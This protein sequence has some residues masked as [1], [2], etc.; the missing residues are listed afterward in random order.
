MYGDDQEYLTSTSAD[1]I[2]IEGAKNMYVGDIVELSETNS[3]LVYWSVN[4]TDVISIDRDK[5]I[6]TAIK[7][8]TATVTASLASDPTKKATV[9]ITVTACGVLLVASS[10]SF[11]RC[12]SLEKLIINAVNPNCINTSVTKFRLSE[13]VKIYVPKGSKEMYINNS[14]WSDYSE[15]IY[16]LD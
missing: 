1:G 13:N 5:G 14:V 10:N 6:A 4:N 3:K 9:K 15:Q 7:N 8:G 12:S 11:D 2:E 16:E